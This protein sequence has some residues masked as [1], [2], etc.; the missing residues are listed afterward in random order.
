MQTAPQLTDPRGAESAALRRCCPLQLSSPLLQGNQEEADN[1]NTGIGA[2]RFM[3]ESNKG[4]S[5]LEFQVGLRV[6]RRVPSCR[7][8]RA[9]RFQRA[10]GV[11][12]MAPRVCSAAGPAGGVGFGFLP[13]EPFGVWRMRCHRPHSGG[14]EAAL[15][16][17]HAMG[18][19]VQRQ[20]FLQPMQWEQ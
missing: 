6:P 12:P 15:P 14:A 8:L 7:A 9:L 3:L 5:M 11:L 10:F 2:F 18:V 13:V 20:P 17:A 16:S 4:K 19:V 1:P